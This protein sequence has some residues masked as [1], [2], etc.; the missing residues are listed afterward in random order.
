MEPK[1]EVKY[2]GMTTTKNELRKHGRGRVIDVFELKKAGQT[3]RDIATLLN[4][5]PQMAQALL[6]PP[7]PVMKTVKRRAKGTCERCGVVPDRGHFHHVSWKDKTISDVNNAGNLSY[8]CTSCHRSIHAHPQLGSPIVR[9]SRPDR[10]VTTELKRGDL[11][12]LRLPN[13]LPDGR[14]ELID[15]G[16]WRVTGVSGDHQHVGI[17]K[18]NGKSYYRVS[19]KFVQKRN[20]S[21]DRPNH[22]C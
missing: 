4:V 13:Y 1:T 12:R 3:Y 6:R 21:L 8:F 2:A 19:S 15:K 18:T 22:L 14:V 9:D 11:V 16:T 20:Y 5:T 17:K 10:T 7:K